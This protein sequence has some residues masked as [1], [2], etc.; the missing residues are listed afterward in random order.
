MS[1]VENVR[2]MG[3]TNVIPDIVKY[4]T[5]GPLAKNVRSIGITE[6]NC[7]NMLRFAF[8]KNVRSDPWVM[9]LKVVDTPTQHVRYDVDLGVNQLTACDY[10]YLCKH[11]VVLYAACF[12]FH[13][14]AR[15][16]LVFVDLYVLLHLVKTKLHRMQSS[17]RRRWL[18][19]VVLESS[20]KCRGVRKTV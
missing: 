4:Q 20:L 5:H 7:C 12:L 17:E 19:A 11:H 2:P 13:N 14:A 3:L 8:K 10:V 9:A 16:F 15:F 1:T 6:A 18:A